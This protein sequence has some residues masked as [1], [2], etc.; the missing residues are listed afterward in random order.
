MSVSKVY[1]YVRR[2]TDHQNTE[3]QKLAIYKYAEKEGMIITQWFDVGCSSRKSNKDRRIDELLETIDKGDTLIVAELSRLGRSV[4][5]MLS[6]IDKLIKKQAKVI[7]LKENIRLEG[8]HDI[9]SKV[10]ITLIGLFAEIERDLISERTREGLERARAK[11]KLLG[12]P[13]GK[14]KSKLDPY[15]EEIIALLKIGSSKT[16]L[17]K[18]YKVTPPTLYNWLKKNEIT[19]NAEL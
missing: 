19:V 13:K 18:K 8:E 14:G 1:A 17:A 3:N 10:M 4:G 11:G 5:Q 15:N 6:I 7:S 12:R 2:S 9:Q 16:Y